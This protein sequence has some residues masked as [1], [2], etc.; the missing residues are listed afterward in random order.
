M[1]IS[2]VGEKDSIVQFDPIKTLIH[3]GLQFGS[4]LIEVFLNGLEE[5]FS[6]L[7]FLFTRNIARIEFRQTPAGLINPTRKNE[8][9][10]LKL[11]RLGH[12]SLVTPVGL[13]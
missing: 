11:N 9:I 2:V 10:L 5:N 3:L 4:Y 13:G 8:I 7:Q 1:D 12:F 6:P